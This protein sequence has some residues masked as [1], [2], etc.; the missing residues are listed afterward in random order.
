[1]SDVYKRQTYVLAGVLLALASG[2]VYWVMVREGLGRFAPPV[3]LALLLV[4]AGLAVYGWLNR[5]RL[6]L[7]YGGGNVELRGGGSV[8]AL[9]DR[10]RA[11]VR[12][13]VEH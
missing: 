8:A 1:A 5:Y 11:T 13:V 9:A 7:Y 10:L 12:A 4:G 2:G 3:A 6:R